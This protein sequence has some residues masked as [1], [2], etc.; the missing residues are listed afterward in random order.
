MVVLLAAAC[1]GSPKVRSRPTQV[2]PWRL[3][4]S[5]GGQG[6]EGHSRGDRRLRAAVLMSQ[7][8][9][10]DAGAEAQAVIDL[11]AQFGYPQRVALPLAVMVESALRRGNT[12]EARSVFE[13]YGSSTEH[14]FR[15]GA[16]ASGFFADLQWAQALVADA[17]GD[18]TTAAVALAPIGSQLYAGFF[19]ARTMHHRL[20]QLVRIALS[21]G[22]EDEARQL[23]AM[24]D[25]LARRN[26]H[27][28]TLS[29]ASHHAQ[30]LVEHEPA[31]LD[32]A[33]Q[34]AVRSEDRLL[35]AAAREDLAQMLA[36]KL[37][38]ARAVEHLEA[39][40]GFYVRVGAQRDTARVR[41]ALRALGVQKRQ[42]SVARPQ[43]GWASLSRSELAVVEL[44]AGGLTKPG[45]RQ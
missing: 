9:L 1:G 38:T 24:V 15:D 34:L 41:A 26:P 20:A 3:S 4:P 18:A 25:L 27:V 40:Y 39:A 29:A 22:A 19:I 6:S 43:Q 8:E 32:R 7:G 2:G 11:P 42:S 31:L 17:G 14:F 12:A 13:R 37:L 5:N 35:E 28:G 23:A 36:T 21:A 33:V 10:D 16:G 44:V 45:R 30:A